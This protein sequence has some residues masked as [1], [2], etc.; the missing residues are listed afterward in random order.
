MDIAAKTSD[1]RI[2][3]GASFGP[4]DGRPVLFVAGA[5][6]GRS[7]RFAEDLLDEAGVRLLTM[8]RPGIGKSTVD[9]QR[10][11]ASTAADYRTF[12]E[13]A[14]GESAIPVVAN[15]QGGVFGLAAAQA[16]WVSRLVLVS[17]ADELAY[18]AIAAMLPAEATQLAVLAREDPQAAAD[19][20]RTFTAE[21]MEAMVLN[22]AHES[23]RAFYTSPDFHPLYRR[24][25]AEGFANDGAGYVCDTLI[26]MRPW[27]LRFAEIPTPVMILFGAHDLGHSPDH[28]ATL[29]RRIPGARREVVPG[30]GGALLWTHSGEVLKAL[31]QH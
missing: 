22:G 7:M 16:G 24:S 2:L 3:A 14:T 28:G 30:A 5:A 19:V 10:T 17:P 9:P 20:L 6:T 29:T 27:E 11:L 25:L 4:L 15:S 21:S 31:S 18:S 13:S 1:G 26:A 8:D 12:A 23:D